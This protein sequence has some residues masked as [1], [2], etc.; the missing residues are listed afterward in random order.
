[1]GT[2]AVAIVVDDHRRDAFHQLFSMNPSLPD[3]RDS[4]HDKLLPFQLWKAR[5][6]R[7]RQ[8]RGSR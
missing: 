3:V 1:M 6:A 2:R 5:S 4:L 8:G 7:R